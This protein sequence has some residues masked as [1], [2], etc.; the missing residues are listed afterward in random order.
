MLSITYVL[1]KAPFLRSLRT[2][3]IVQC[4]NNKRRL[5]LDAI[6][7]NRLLARNIYFTFV[8]TMFISEDVVYVVYTWR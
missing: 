5:L 1:I 8:L 2:V 6:R 7:G 3:S 4:T